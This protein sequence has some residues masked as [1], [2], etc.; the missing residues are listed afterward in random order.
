MFIGFCL[1][2]PLVY[3]IAGREIK[4]SQCRHANLWL[5]SGV[6]TDGVLSLIAGE[7]WE[8]FTQLTPSSW[9]VYIF[10]VAA[11]TS[12]GFTQ[13]LSVSRVK[14][15]LFSTLLS[16]RLL[17]VLGA[18]WVL[19]G[20]WLTSVWQGAGVVIVFLTITLY[21]RHQADYGRGCSIQS[22]NPTDQESNS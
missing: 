7:R 10:L 3:L 2:V 14:A 13:V 5:L 6:V 9:V 16:W 18:S 12:G 22:P 15:T 19:L 20:E 17:V 11:I 4:W 21:P 1:T 8:S